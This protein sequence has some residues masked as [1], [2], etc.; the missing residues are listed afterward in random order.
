MLFALKLINAVKLSQSNNQILL[1]IKCAE[2]LLIRKMKFH[3]L[4]TKVHRWLVTGIS[5]VR[6]SWLI[7]FVILDFSFVLNANIQ[8][9]SMQVLWKYSCRTFL[10]KVHDLIKQRHHIIL[11]LGVRTCKT[12]VPNLINIFWK[13]ST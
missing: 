10:L 12:T 5:V 3:L 8:Y 1:F 6:F 4:Y 9:A 13:K 7:F 2:L 11:V